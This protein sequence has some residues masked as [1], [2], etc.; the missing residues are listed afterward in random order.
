MTIF[1]KTAENL[2]LWLLK[3]AHKKNYRNK[4]LA[5]YHQLQSFGIIYDASQEENY[6]L[7][8]HLVKDLQQDQRKVK[9]LGFAIQKKMPDYCFPKLTFE[10][11]NRKNFRILQAPK[12]Q[13]V[14]DFISQP[15]DVLIDF[16]PSTFYYIKYLTAISGSAMKTGFFA[17]K[18][19][20]IYDLMIEMKDDA[21]LKSKI[22]QVFLYLKMINGNDNSE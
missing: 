16:T 12:A 13:N 5:G 21:P 6:R 3:N 2:R 10:F 11:C 19:I 4:K 22:E 8:T 9:T 7:I 15:F 18:H 1:G 20:D 14:K 17:E